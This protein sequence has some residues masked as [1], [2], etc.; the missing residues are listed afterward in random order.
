MALWSAGATRQHSLRRL[1][2]KW[3]GTCYE[4]THIPGNTEFS[5]QWNR[6][7]NSGGNARAP[8]A[9]LWHHQRQP[10][11]DCSVTASVSPL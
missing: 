5:I 7:S 6:S 4:S 8:V 1:V 10:L 2:V 9:F 3:T 11:R